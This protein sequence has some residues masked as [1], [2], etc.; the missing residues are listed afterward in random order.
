M[1]Y[2]PLCFIINSFFPQTA[3][4]D[5]KAH[6]DLWF[7][8]FLVCGLG[9]ACWPIIP[10]GK[11]LKKAIRLLW[12]PGPLKTFEGFFSSNTLK[13]SILN[14]L[15]KTY[16][17]ETAWLQVKLHLSPLQL[18]PTMPLV[19]F[20]ELVQI[21]NIVSIFNLLKYFSQY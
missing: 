14:D 8:D 10:K 9:L 12:T 11:S 13:W 17:K 1:S 15:T 3:Q 2:W 19:L 18:I 5:K 7:L 6:K 16:L 21:L 20:W 4:E